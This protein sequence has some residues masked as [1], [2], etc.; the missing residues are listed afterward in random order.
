MHSCSTRPDA[1]AQTRYLSFQAAGPLLRVRS[2]KAAGSRARR[3]GA[4]GAHR[5]IVDR[6]V[7]AGYRIEPEA[8]DAFGSR[9]MRDSPKSP[10]GHATRR[11]LGRATSICTRTA[12]PRGPPASCRSNRVSRGRVPCI[13]I[14]SGRHK[15]WGS[16]PSCCLGW[17]SLPAPTRYAHRARRSSSGIA[18]ETPNSLMPKS[19]RQA[20]KRLPGRRARPLL[21]RPGPTPACPARAVR[22]VAVGKQALQSSRL[23]QEQPVRAARAAPRKRDRSARQ[24]AQAEWRCAAT[25]K[26]ECRAAPGIRVRLHDAATGSWKQGKPVMATTVRSRVPRRAAAPR[27]SSLGLLPNVML[28]V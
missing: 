24:Q 2:L 21:R 9:L 25:A 5:T 27:R 11:C 22:V 10:H 19:A 28:N 3:S 12:G 4:T 14:G 6:A 13:S 8:P 20:N 18:F 16:A 17:R 15:V 1:Q 26:Q 23:I 7:Q